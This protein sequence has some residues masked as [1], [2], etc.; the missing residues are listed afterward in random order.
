MNQKVTKRMIY[1]ISSSQASTVSSLDCKIRDGT[2]EWKF[3]QKPSFP[4]VPGVS[5]PRFYDFSIHNLHGFYFINNEHC[6]I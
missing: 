4:M 1:Y 6:F 3:G 5:F 2:F